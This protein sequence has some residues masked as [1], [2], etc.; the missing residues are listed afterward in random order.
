MS[1]V[2]KNEYQSKMKN[3]VSADS[4]VS[5]YYDAEFPLVP[6]LESISTDQAGATVTALDVQKNKVRIKFNNQLESGKIISLKVKPKR[7]I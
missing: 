6:D 7:M 2:L 3:A 5:L 4:W 1:A